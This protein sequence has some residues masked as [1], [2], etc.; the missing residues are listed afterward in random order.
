MPR[1]QTSVRLQKTLLNLFLF[2]LPVQLGYHWWPDWSLVS[3]IRV[4]YLSPTLYLTDIVLCL[5][6]VLDWKHVTKLITRNVLI[7]LVMTVFAAI[8]IWF[9]KAPEVSVYS[10]VRFFEYALFVQ[11]VIRNASLVK[12]S[13]RLTFPFMLSW[14]SL[15]AIAQWIN[16]GSLNGL[17]YWVGE[18]SF[19]VE[20]P[21][22]ALTKFGSN[23]SLRPY[24]T[25]PHPNALAGFLLIAWISL[26]ACSPMKIVFWINTVLVAITLI[27]TE[28]VPVYIVIAALFTISIGKRLGLTVTIHAKRSLLLSVVFLSLLSPL[29][30]LMLPSD[31]TSR[32]G[33]S[34]LERIELSILSGDMILKSPFVGIGLGGYI[35]QIPSYQN[36]L[37]AVYR[38]RAVSLYQPVHNVPLL[39]FSEVGAIGLFFSL[40]SIPF[41]LLSPIGLGVFI[42]SLFD[43]YWATL[44]QPILLL[45]LCVG[46]ALSEKRQPITS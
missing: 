22:I 7:L 8:N 29:L 18:R 32:I 28:S 15:L 2:I 12:E 35:S 13:I 42:I 30:F 45:C 27:L 19:S 4:D 21:G 26:K 11:Y 20:T 1:G 17:L 14:V 16:R 6:L 23:V 41:I 36:D 25:L 39:I 31:L 10:W 24:A 37:P 33:K 3:G 43:H 44:H 5:L 40:V 38:G 34:S 9:S 46:I